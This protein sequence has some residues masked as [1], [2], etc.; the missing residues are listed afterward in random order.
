MK[1]G[2]ITLLVIV[3]TSLISLVVNA[4]EAQA[5][6][7]NEMKESIIHTSATEWY[8][9]N[10]WNV[11]L[12]TTYAFTQVDY[13]SAGNTFIG[14][15]APSD[16]YVAADHAWGGGIDVKLFFGRYFGLGVEAYGIGAGRTVVD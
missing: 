9:D 11:A 5:Q 10:E 12:W 6:S 2:I 13:P 7:S 14:L 4:S 8:A 3:T 15:R 1:H 16:R